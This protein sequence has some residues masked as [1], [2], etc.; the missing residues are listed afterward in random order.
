MLARNTHTAVRRTQEPEAYLLRGGYV[1]CAHCG[2]VMSVR[3]DHG[4]REYCCMTSRNAPSRCRF[5]H[6]KQAPL[7]EAIWSWVSSVL[8]E[9]A[10]IAQAVAEQQQAEGGDPTAARRAQA[11]RR[12]DDIARQQANLA[13]AVATLGQGASAA[14]LLALLETL[15]PQAREVQADLDALDRERTAWAGAQAQLAQ[16]LDWCQTVAANLPSLTYA[17]KQTALDALDVQVKVYPAPM[18]EPVHWRATMHPLGAGQVRSLSSADA[19][20][21]STSVL[22]D[23]R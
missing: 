15:A 20:P 1:R 12:R 9:P 3:N 23:M 5:H 10:I 22:S 2:H 17:E 6:I 4:H 14:P 19:G 8:R 7:D 11:E 16:V 18:G 21:F 13:A